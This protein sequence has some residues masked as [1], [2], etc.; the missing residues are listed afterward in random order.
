MTHL[1]LDTTQV[2][3]IDSGPTLVECLDPTGRVVG[4]LHVASRNDAVPVPKVT[5]EQLAAYEQEPGGRNLQ[6]ILSDLR[7]RRS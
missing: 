1:T 3:Q 6:E 4:F 7:K 2:Q 5:A